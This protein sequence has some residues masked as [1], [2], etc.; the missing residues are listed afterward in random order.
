MAGEVAG[1][2][3]R[4]RVLLG[5]TGG[6]AAYKVAH[7]VRLLTQSGAEVQISDQAVNRLKI[8]PLIAGISEHGS[9]GLR[10]KLLGKSHP[11]SAPERKNRGAR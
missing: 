5:V 2:L 7:L 9:D 8:A 11:R 6:I 1:S 3:E 10:D 4:R